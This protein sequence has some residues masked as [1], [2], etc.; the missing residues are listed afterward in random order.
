M[1]THTTQ[2]FVETACYCS[3]HV[4]SFRTAQAR[5]LSVKLPMTTTGRKLDF[6]SPELLIEALMGAEGPSY[7]PLSLPRVCLQRFSRLPAQRTFSLSLLLVVFLKI[8]LLSVKNV[9]PS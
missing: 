8:V 5:Q 7:L 2:V 4:Q 1:V 6:F 9:H 3:R